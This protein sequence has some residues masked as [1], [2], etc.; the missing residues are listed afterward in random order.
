MD[1]K[2]AKAIHRSDQLLTTISNNSSSNMRMMAVVHFEQVSKD[3]DLSKEDA[4]YFLL[5][6]SALAYVTEIL[7]I[8]ESGSE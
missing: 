1:K 2:T 6:G 8:S 5:A 4:L 3:P 7:S